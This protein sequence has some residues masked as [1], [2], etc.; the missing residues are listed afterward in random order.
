MD[1]GF[2]IDILPRL[3]RASVTTL[4]VSI[5][6][7]ILG[8]LLGVSMGVL[9]VIG[10]RVF[11]PLVDAYVGLVRGTPIAVQ[12]YAAFFLL[13]RVGADFTLFQISIIAL[14]FNSTGYQIEIVRAA[15]QSIDKRQIEAAASIGLTQ[16][17]TMWHITLPQA[18]QRMI[19]PLTNELANLIKASSV[20]SIIALYEL[21]RAGHAIIAANFKYA[22]VLILV[23]ILYFA[24]IQLLTEGANYL[25]RDVFNFEKK[26]AS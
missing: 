19:P 2:M 12:I 8:L 16:F 13:P 10:P 9:R 20:L 25:E 7:L 6:S 24:A 14:T 17:K 5:V 15:L 23:S 3:L 22:E 21:T 4:Q 11:H 1:I 26:S 18:A